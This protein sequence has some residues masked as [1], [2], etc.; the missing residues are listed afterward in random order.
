L[1]VASLFARPTSELSVEINYP[2]LNANRFINLTLGRFVQH[3]FAV[4]DQ[5]TPTQMVGFLFAHLLETA[6]WGRLSEDERSEYRVRIDG[7]D[8]ATLPLSEVMR[9]S[10][11]D[12]VW[13]VTEQ[14]G[15][16]LSR[17]ETP[18]V[19]AVDSMGVVSVRINHV[20]QIRVVNEAVQQLVEDVAFGRLSG[21]EGD[22]GKRAV[23]KEYVRVEGISVM[24][25][26]CAAAG[27]L[28]KSAVLLSE[29]VSQ[30]NDRRLLDVLAR[31]AALKIDSGATVKRGS[32]F[33][34]VCLRSAA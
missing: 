5:D 24:I 25:V 26:T 18:L 22:D 7:D 27:R 30:W 10:L 9:R 1:C 31:S 3:D 29:Q 2:G 6:G 4:T 14:Y 11:D 33:T 20:R 8:T 17:A 28:V 21:Y 34:V 23:W 15:K 13:L 12:R 19:V 16:P 32:E